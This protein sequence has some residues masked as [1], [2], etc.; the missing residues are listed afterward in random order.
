M[1]ELL[2]TTN[3][4]CNEFEGYIKNIAEEKDLFVG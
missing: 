1:D 2:E 3:G 4:V